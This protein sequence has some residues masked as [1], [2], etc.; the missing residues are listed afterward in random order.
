VG[1]SETSQQVLGFDIT[2]V[3]LLEENGFVNNV[4]EPASPTKSPSKKSRHRQQNSAGPE[5]PDSRAEL[6]QEAQIMLD[7]E[8]LILAFDA[9]E[10]F[11][12]AWDE[13]EQ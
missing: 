11:Q 5:S 4:S 12:L 2:E 13:H 3:P 7:L 1:L 9:L 8:R 6:Y 10:N